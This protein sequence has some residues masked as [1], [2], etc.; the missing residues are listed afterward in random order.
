M[1]SLTPQAMGWALILAA[2]ACAPDTPVPEVNVVGTAATVAERPEEGLADNHLIGPPRLSPG[3]FERKSR[4]AANGDVAAM[5]TLSVHHLSISQVPEAY[6]WLRKAAKL[7]DCQAIGHLIEDT[8][9][10][11]EPDEMPHWRRERKRLGCDPLKSYVTPQIN[12][13]PEPQPER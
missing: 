4:Q 5:H 1:K 3:E 10:G 2:A 13:H 12:R 7:G 8:F 9:D 11:V 6:D